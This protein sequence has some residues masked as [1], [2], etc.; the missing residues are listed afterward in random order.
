MEKGLLC[1]SY[2]QTRQNTYVI[3]ETPLF[4]AFY[5]EMYHMDSKTR[6]KDSR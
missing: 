1:N 6:V 2:Y 5:K 3:E 4:L